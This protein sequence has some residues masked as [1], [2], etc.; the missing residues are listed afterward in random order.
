MK[1]NRRIVALP[2]LILLAVASGVC[3]VWIGEWHLKQQMKAMVATTRAIQSST[4][5][6]LKLF[7]TDYELLSQYSNDVELS[8]A[9]TS[10]LLGLNQQLNPSNYIFLVIYHGKV[11]NGLLLDAY[12]RRIDF[13]LVVQDDRST[14]NNQ[15]GRILA[16]AD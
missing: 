12:G 14:T 6:L 13:R 15:K 7:P 5:N 11:E 2:A 16:V 9:I 8:K 3:G 4:D 1:S 10:A